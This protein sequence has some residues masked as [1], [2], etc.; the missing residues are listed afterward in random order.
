MET[1]RLDAEFLSTKKLVELGIFVESTASFWAGDPEG[2]MN[3]YR[4]REDDDSYG[5]PAPVTDIAEVSLTSGFGK[6]GRIRVEQRAPLPIRV[7]AIVG[8]FVKGSS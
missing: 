8:D 2:E 7:M 3:E 5:S 1:L 6:G 4:T